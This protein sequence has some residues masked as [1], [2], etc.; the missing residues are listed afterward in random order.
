MAVIVIVASAHWTE[1]ERDPVHGQNDRTFIR[2]AGK[3]R[4]RTDFRFL[5]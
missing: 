5:T 1:T 3:C 4:Y 2:W